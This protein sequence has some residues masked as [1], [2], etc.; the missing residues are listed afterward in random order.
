MQFANCSEASNRGALIKTLHWAAAKGQRLS[1]S[2]SSDP[3]TKYGLH[4]KITSGPI[5]AASLAQQ[6]APHLRRAQ[7]RSARWE[8]TRSA[9]VI[10]KKR[11][12]FSESLGNNKGELVRIFHR[13]RSNHGRTF[14]SREH[15]LSQRFDLNHSRRTK[16]RKLIKIVKLMKFMKKS[17]IF[18]GK[19]IC[20]PLKVQLK[21]R[22]HKRKLKNTTGGEQFGLKFRPPPL[23]G[24]YQQ[25]AEIVSIHFQSL[26]SGP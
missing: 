25:P 8:S 6:S 21:A 23:L 15:I 1:D 11:K 19:R 13:K 3:L 17:T 7:V 14:Y 10:E 12:L 2:S 22:G 9:R 18:K 16:L 4:S 5:K 26:G 20:S 24:N